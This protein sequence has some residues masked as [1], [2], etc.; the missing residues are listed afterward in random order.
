L[1]HHNLREHDLLKILTDLA[2]STVPSWLLF[3]SKSPSTSVKI[4]EY[5]VWE[6]TR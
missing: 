3:F 1:L 4:I 6:N 5:F 2:I